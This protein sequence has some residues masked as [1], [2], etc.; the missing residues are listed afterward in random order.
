MTWGYYI[1]IY[2]VASD[3]IFIICYLTLANDNWIKTGFKRMERNQ[4][5]I[6]VSCLLLFAPLLIMYYIIKYAVLFI[7]SLPRIFLGLIYSIICPKSARIRK[8]NMDLY[9]SIARNFEQMLSDV[10]HRNIDA[11]KVL[12]LLNCVA[13]D[14]NCHIGYR[15]A[16]Y[17]NG[18]SGDNANLYWYEGDDWQNGRQSRH[19]DR[20]IYRLL[21]PEIK[22]CKNT[23]FEHLNVE[24][25]ELGAWQAY[26][27]SVSSTMLPAEW[28]GLYYTRF[29]VFTRDDVKKIRHI[30][31]R[32]VWWLWADVSPK[33]W[34]KDDTAYVRCCYWND[35]DGL[36][37]ET[38][39]LK[40]EGNH[41]T[42]IE[43]VKEK[44]LYRYNNPEI[45]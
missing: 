36:I 18:E 16:D 44:K 8:E 1:L 37:S 27:L 33:V 34:I 5:W 14:N 23:V 12:T 42:R 35:W 10:V 30:G 26:L 9:I 31:V 28:H 15:P 38:M 2:W 29:F 24:K 40:Y 19:S 7:C 21:L 20:C 3:I 43:M 45:L 25:S 32:L 11:D 13:L 41:I 4:L 22:S 6:T 17:N 39:A